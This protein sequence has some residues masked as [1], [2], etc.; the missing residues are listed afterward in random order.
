[1]PGEGKVGLG[2][3]LFVTEVQESQV[4]LCLHQYRFHK[5]CEA[6]RWDG[7]ISAV[8]HTFFRQVYFVRPPRPGEG[9]RWL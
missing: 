2:L 3:F 1:M 4:H 6:C 9:V 7:D 8:R 5:E